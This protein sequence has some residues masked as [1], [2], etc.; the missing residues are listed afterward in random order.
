M[1]TSKRL[2]IWGGGSNSAVG[3]LHAS[4]SRLDGLWNIVAGAF[5]RN[6]KT[7]LETIDKY[8]LQDCSLYSSLEE[9]VAQESNLDAIAVLTPT[10]L[11]YEGCMHIL[12]NGK[13]SILCEK[14]VSTSVKEAIKLADAAAE[15][16]VSFYCFYNYTGYPMIREAKT[17]INEG[18]IG[19][20]ISVESNMLQ[21]TFLNQIDNSPVRPQEWRLKDMDI[22][23]VSLDLGVHV[24]NLIEFVCSKRL[25]QVTS[26]HTSLGNFQGI[27]D[28]VSGNAIM[29]DNIQCTFKYGKAFLG[30]ENDFSIEIY[31]TN[32]SISW[33]QKYPDELI[34]SSQGESKHL[35][36]SNNSII[37]ASAYRY[38]RFKAGHPTGFVEA[39]G[40]YYYDL[41]YSNY[42]YIFGIDESIHNMKVLDAIHKSAKNDSLLMQIN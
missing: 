39:F 34:L 8:N 18:V 9:M 29:D 21:Q 2:G 22:P 4:A 35:H 14:T 13:C 37:E 36:L 10:P 17:L 7:N 31:G 23:C 28:Y 1:A 24:I 20:I 12:Q 19:N 26:I 6:P 11:H 38:Q 33:S 32:G 30:R 42:N 5:S 15:K 16:N 40:N 41:Y 3:R 25:T 27:I